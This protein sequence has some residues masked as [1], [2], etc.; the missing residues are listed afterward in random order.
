MTGEPAAREVMKRREY[1]ITLD[2]KAGQAQGAMLTTDLSEEY[3]KNKCRLSIVV[4]K[5]DIV[6]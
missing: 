6:A 4:R 5:I 1:V 3:V 2:L